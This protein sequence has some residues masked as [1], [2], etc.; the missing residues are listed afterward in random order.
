A[1]GTALATTDYTCYN[2]GGQVQRIIRNY[3]PRPTDPPPDTLEGTRE[4]WSH[5]FDFTRSAQP[6]VSNYWGSYE[7]GTGFKTENKSDSYGTYEAVDP[8][9]TFPHAVTLTRIEMHFTVTGRGGTPYFNDGDYF[10][11]DCNRPGGCPP[12][13][14]HLAFWHLLGDSVSPRVWTGRT[15]LRSLRLQ[16]LTTALQNPSLHHGVVSKVVL[17]GVGDDP[18]KTTPC[19]QF[20]P[21]WHGQNA[22]QNLITSLG[23]DGAGRQIEVTDP[24]GSKTL[25]GYDKGGRLLTQTDPLGS[26]T[27][28][29]YDRLGRRVLVVQNWAAAG[30]SDPAE[31]HWDGTHW[32][33]G[34]GTVVAHGERND[35]NL[36]VQVE[37]DKGG[38]MLTLRDPRGNR[39]TYTYDLLDRRRSLTDPLNQRW[40]TAYFNLNGTTRT[41]HTN[42]LQQ[43]TRHDTDEAGRL[44]RVEYLDESPKL[45][46]DVFFRYDKGGRR[47]G[48]DESLDLGSTWVRRTQFSHDL[49]GRL[50][51]VAFD[52]DG[53]GTPEQTVSYRYEAGGLRTQ[54]IL[55]E[56][57]TVTYQYDVRGQLV[58]VT[59]WEDNPTAFRFDQVGRLVQTLRVNGF[60]SQYAY[61]AGGR[62]VRL[63]HTRDGQSLGHFEYTV[64]GR[65]NRIQTL[66]CLPRV[67]GGG[68]TLLHDDP[69]VQ[70]V[71]GVWED[72]AGFRQTTS[73][74]AALRL[75]VV[76]TALSLSM[77]VGPDH[78]L[79][80]V[81]VNGS[82]WRTVNGYAPQAGVTTLE[83]TLSREGPH[84]IQVRNR[85]D[86][87][88]RATGY[89]LRFHKL[90]SNRAYDL[91][92]LHYHYD[93]LSRLVNADYHPG[94]NPTGTPF[95]EYAYQYD[96][97][98]NRTRETMTVEGV[99]TI[100][101]WTYN[102]MNQISSGGVTYD[103]AGRMTSDG[104]NP[105]TWDRADRLLSMG[106][107]GYTYNGLGQRVGQSHN[108]LVTSYLNDLQPGLVKLLNSDT[109]GDLTWYLHTPMGIHQQQN[110]DQSWVYPVQDG[111][112]SVRAVV[113]AAGQILESRLYAP[114][115]D[116]FGGSGTAQTGFGFT[117][118]V[119]DSNGLLYLRARYYLPGLG[120]FPSLDPVEEGN[121]YG[122]VGGD[123]VNRVD[124]SGECYF[125]SEETTSQERLICWETWQNY[126]RI[127]EQ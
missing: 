52:T 63:S 53:D 30:L 116:P 92:T 48:M 22:D 19:Y 44:K 10:Y 38:R 5:T 4:G 112:G 110:P 41:E 85:N 32:V 115:G 102:G 95:R 107:L 74:T 2:R 126:T 23:Y 47:V 1:A 91:H 79:F 78:S 45:T 66:E 94:A 14:P 62:L 43:V 99:P 58:G 97:V 108:G 98:G 24:T 77:G 15:T 84:Q 35:R 119:T 57:Q 6:W 124:P 121:R 73:L 103:A 55:P 86:R 40:E 125:N 87:D 60:A 3:R 39:S 105:F 12:A 65:G 89:T 104:V 118:E 120:V 34:K 68:T 83:M 36:P 7:P 37:Y 28:Y 114:Y 18:F 72:V 90:E 76:G 17:E 61:D 59:D 100:T 13:F 9:I 113:D 33:D 96:G 25:M 54:L 88:L 109:E 81:Y 31:W 64:D 46:P 80:E 26:I 50:N 82:L 127:I 93:A 11:A 29:R 49:A 70:S 69:A 123:V 101:N 122:Y 27:T 117:G 111:L 75:S 42:P 51:Q 20:S 71:R 21:E 56:G 8:V 106:G 67:G 16:L